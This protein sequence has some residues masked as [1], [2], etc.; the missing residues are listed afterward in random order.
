MTF[1]DEPGIYILGEFGIRLEDDMHITERAQNCSPRKA[2]RWRTR[3]ERRRGLHSSPVTQDRDGQWLTA[4]LYGFEIQL[5]KWRYAVKFR[6]I[7]ALRCGLRHCWLPVDLTTCPFPL[8][9]LTTSK[10][11]PVS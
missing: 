5:S 2:R 4:Y 10:Q 11:S 8:L 7:T 3:S 9:H 1:S 6:S